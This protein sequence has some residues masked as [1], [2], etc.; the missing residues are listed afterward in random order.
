MDAD[1]Y[2]HNTTAHGNDKEIQTTVTLKTNTTKLSFK[3]HS[4]HS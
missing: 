4:R 1:I 3:Q 2:I